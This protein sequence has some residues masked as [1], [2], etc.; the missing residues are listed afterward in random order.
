MAANLNGF[1]N[2]LNR[3]VLSHNPEARVQIPAGS[4]LPLMPMSMPSDQRFVGTS[5]SASSLAEHRVEFGVE[6]D[7]PDLLCTAAGGSD[8]GSPFQ[9]L[10]A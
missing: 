6:S 4:Q 8:F 7:L 3:A 1:R 10:L 2:V 5:P 9:R